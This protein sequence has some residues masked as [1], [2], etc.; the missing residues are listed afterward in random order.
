MQGSVPLLHTHK[1]SSLQPDYLEEQRLG[2]RSW[3]DGMKGTHHVL[4]F[5]SLALFTALLEAAWG[6]LH[7]RGICGDTCKGDRKQADRYMCFLPCWYHGMLQKSAG[8]CPWWWL[9]SLWLLYSALKCYI[10]TLP[11]YT[12]L[13]YDLRWRAVWLSHLQFM[14]WSDLIWVSKLNK[15]HHVAYGYKRPV[16]VQSWVAVKHPLPEAE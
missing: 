6:A 5:L 16:R 7:V 8:M 3:N 14:I 10:R 2:R 9:P 15:P 13:L 11:S 4:I 12:L 1:G